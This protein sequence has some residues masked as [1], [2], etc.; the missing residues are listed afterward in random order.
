MALLA[1]SYPFRLLQTFVIEI[2]LLI[3]FPSFCLILFLLE[4]L[5]R[6]VIL[7]SPTYSHLFICACSLSVT[8]Q[9]T[10]VCLTVGMEILQAQMKCSC[11]SSCDYTHLLCDT[12]GDDRTAG[13]PRGQCALSSSATWQRLP[14]CSKEVSLLICVNEVTTLQVQ[15]LR[16]HTIHIQVQIFTPPCMRTYTKKSKHIRLDSLISLL[17]SPLICRDGEVVSTHNS[18]SLHT[19]FAIDQMEMAFKECP[20]AL[21]KASDQ[22]AKEAE[23]SCVSFHPIYFKADTV[24][25]PMEWP[26][27]NTE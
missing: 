1:E 22:R 5:S 7:P 10:C 12:D 9:W 4:L 24:F 11:D 16:E 3:C 2:A 25:F 17:L 8:L 23:F 6:F 13:V 18:Q 20:H 26:L 19:E 14:S 27:W 21:R 15:P